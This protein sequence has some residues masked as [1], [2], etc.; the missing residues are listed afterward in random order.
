VETRTHD[1]GVGLDVVAPGDGGELELLRGGERGP[2]E[3]E[4]A[5]ELTQIE[6]RGSVLALVQVSVGAQPRR[7]VGGLARLAAEPHRVQHA[8]AVKPV[9]RLSAAVDRRDRVGTDPKEDPG[10]HIRRELPLVEPERGGRKLGADWRKVALRVA[11]GLFSSH[12]F[13]LQG[14]QRLVELGDIIH[15]LLDG[16][17]RLIVC[18]LPLLFLTELFLV[19]PR[20]PLRAVRVSLE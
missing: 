8:V 19:P 18:R 3:A 11:V 7:R 15:C 1:A 17:A 10:R 20:P 13:L 12:G 5:E 14:A 2:E 6:E 16:A 4:E 9:V